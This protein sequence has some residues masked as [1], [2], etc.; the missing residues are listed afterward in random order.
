MCVKTNLQAW[1]GLLFIV[2]AEERVM[3]LSGL[4]RVSGLS[5]F[6]SEIRGLCGMSDS[7]HWE[8]DAPVR[9]P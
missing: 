6:I 4:L 5:V 9:F 8:S 7:H 1:F 3:S 2:S